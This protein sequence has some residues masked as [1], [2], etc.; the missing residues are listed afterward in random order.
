MRRSV[1]V[2][3]YF[4]GFLL[5]LPMVC[6]GEGIIGSNVHF[7]AELVS[8]SNLALLICCLICIKQYFWPGDSIRLPFHVF[9][10]VFIVLFY[11]L[12]LPFLIS[13]IEYYDNYAQLTP[14]AVLGK[15]FFSLNID[16]F[17]Q[18]IILLT[19]V[20][21]VLYIVKY[22]NDYYSIGMPIE[23]EKPPAVIGDTKNEAVEINSEATI[24]E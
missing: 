3:S 20:I 21:N 23:H 17:L 16:S 1:Q 6:M 4:V 13:N 2:I 8:F 15:F 19:G 7:S 22:R 24:A 10:L 18:W 5:L 12:S 14:L 11:S 9:N